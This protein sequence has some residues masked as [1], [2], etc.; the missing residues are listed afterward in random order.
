MT[1]FPMTAGLAASLGVDPKD[2]VGLNSRFGVT[3]DDMDLGMWGQCD[4]LSVDFK[5]EKL[6]GGQ[7]GVYDYEVYLPGQV[8]YPQVTLKRAMNAAHSKRVQSWLAQKLQDWVYAAGTGKS[9]SGVITLYDAKASPVISWSLHNV[10][11]SKWDGPKL[12]ASSAGIAIESLT[13]V[14]EGFL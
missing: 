14:H 5:P 2:I 13:L 3:I 4:G 9:S 12:E 7:G 11:P 6:N 8:S 10:Y 1:F